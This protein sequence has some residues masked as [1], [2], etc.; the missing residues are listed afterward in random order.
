MDRP[1]RS[2]FLS[3]GVALAVAVAV[4]ALLAA[5]GPAGLTSAAVLLCA[6]G[7]AVHALQRARRQR[8]A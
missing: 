8:M 1:E 2:P 6:I 3:R 4:V 7:I 5:G